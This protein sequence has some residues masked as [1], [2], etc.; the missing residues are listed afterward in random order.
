MA[1][2][3]TKPVFLDETGQDIADKLDDIKQA[4][5]DSAGDFVPLLIR[6]TTPPTK[7]SYL[8]GETLN[9]TGIV[10][11][12]VGS[13]GA[14]IDV[15]A[16]C[17]YSPANG[18]TLT[19]EMTSVQISYTY[20]VGSFSFTTSLAINV[21]ELSSIAVTTPPTKT[22]YYTGETLDL[23]GIVVIATYDD[24]STA[25]VTSGC[26]FSPDDGDTLTAS[27]TAISV[28]YSEGSTTKT[29]SQAITVI[30]L[31]SIAVTTPPTK[32]VYKVD[33]TLDLTGIEVTATY[34]DSSTADVTAQCTFNPANGTT[35]DIDD[36][37]VTI[38][39]TAGTTETTS[40][41]ITVNPHMYGVEYYEGNTYSDSAL[42]R[43]GDAENFTFSAS[44]G[45]T[46]GHSDFDNAYPWSEI[47]RVTIDGDVFVKIPKFWYKK[48]VS[49]TKHELWIADGECDG[50]TLHPAFYKGGVEYDYILV[51]AYNTSAGYVSQTGQSPLQ[52]ISLSGARTAVGNKGAGYHLMDIETLNAIQMLI[53]VEIANW[54]VQSTIGMGIVYG[55]ASAQA[56]GGCDSVANLTGRP[57]GTDSG[58]L[59][60][61]WRGIEN[62]WGNSG[63]L[64]DG[65]FIRYSTLHICNDPSKYADSPTS[66]YIEVGLVNWPD[67][68]A[69]IVRWHDT[70]ISPAISVIQELFI[71]RKESG[72]TGSATTY[73]CDTTESAPSDYRALKHGG[74]LNSQTA[75][76]LF[77][78]QWKNAT[79]TDNTGNVR[80]LKLPTT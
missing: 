3:L 58:A 77:M 53:V 66:D 24:G 33:E 49:G 30:G 10:V 13:N 37:S 18:T 63:T 73:K 78:M 55:V 15:T 74:V 17:T 75:A 76:G 9:L 12:L 70:E 11:S 20:P 6:V 19:A 57:S 22:S 68:G 61:V 1:Q 45:S 2:T 21:R 39:Y 26:T 48:Y 65:I 27:D 32:T 47:E 50:F 5:I 62:L 14:M 69:Y 56:T 79:S 4:I 80:L 71:P 46:A 42:T 36:T 41:E 60:V 7:T 31:E 67:N 38:S 25:V 64:I 35:L 28:S 44:V 34:S 52:G 40:Q 43:I 54:N 59:P 29:S 23:T 16:G 51:G 72:Y 8:V